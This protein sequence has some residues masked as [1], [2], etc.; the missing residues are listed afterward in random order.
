MI[1]RALKLYCV[2]QSLNQNVNSS[3]L[4]FRTPKYSKHTL[5]SL[6]FGHCSAEG[7][8]KKT[9]LD[10][11]IETHLVIESNGY[12]SKHAS[13][14]FRFDVRLHV[15][16]LGFV[17]NHYAHI[18][19][20]TGVSVPHYRHERCNAWHALKINVLLLLV[21]PLPVSIGRGRKELPYNFQT[22]FFPQLKGKL[23][24]TS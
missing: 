7:N 22:I 14:N 11:V 15:Y 21:T 3:P 23:F 1:S 17:P 19:A 8:G 20:G 6:I 10:V 5:Q 4:S 2:L 13:T 12:T 9:W 18:I 16:Y 24:G